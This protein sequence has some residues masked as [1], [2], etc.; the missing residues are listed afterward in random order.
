MQILPFSFLPVRKYFYTRRTD[1]RF[2]HAGM[3]DPNKMAKMSILSG[4]SAVV[5]LLIPSYSILLAFPL[6]ILAIIFS[7]L[8][9][10]N[11]ST[12]LNIA[13]FGKLLGI[14]VLVGIT[15]EIILAAFLIAIWSNL[16]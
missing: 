10:K 8:A 11:G 7:R 4:G 3:K 13:E 6:G 9:V 5:F 16:L 12:K 14:L 2:I 15:I 1:T